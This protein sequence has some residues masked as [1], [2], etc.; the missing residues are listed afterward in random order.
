MG[1]LRSDLL[2]HFLGVLWEEAL[3]ALS[4]GRAMVA[5]LVE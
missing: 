3:V 1:K 4:G 5:D 2:S